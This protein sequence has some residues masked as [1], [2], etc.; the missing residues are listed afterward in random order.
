MPAVLAAGSSCYPHEWLVLLVSGALILL[1][2]AAA[3]GNRA[4]AGFV[5][6]NF[7]GPWRADRF[8][9]QEKAAWRDS[10]MGVTVVTRFFTAIFGTAAAAIGIAAIIQTLTCE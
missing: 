5:V 1:G 8:E 4:V 7:I 9:A 10:I 2:I 6:E 3:V